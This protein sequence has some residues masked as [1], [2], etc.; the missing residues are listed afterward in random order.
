MLE[1]AQRWRDNGMKAR[2]FAQEHG[3]TRWMLNY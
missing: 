2:A 3:V 1:L